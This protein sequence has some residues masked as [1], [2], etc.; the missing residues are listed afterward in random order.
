MKPC[1]TRSSSPPPNRSKHARQRLP[2][3][4]PASVVHGGATFATGVR[5]S[6]RLGATFFCWVAG[7]VPMIAASR[8]RVRRT[9]R[10]TCPHWISPAAERQGTCW[11]YCSCRQDV[12]NSA[13][14]VP[15]DYRSHSPHP[16]SRSLAT[17]PSMSPTTSP[18]C[19]QPTRRCS[20]VSDRCSPTRPT[21]RQNSHRTSSQ[22]RDARAHRQPVRRRTRQCHVVQRAEHRHARRA[23]HHVGRH[24]HRHRIGL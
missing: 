18:R 21:S 23:R 2:R 14:A 12:I 20:T 15:T 3:K 5:R 1:S 22:R 11:G 7:R 9:A 19:P 24:L 16:V 4:R 10:T 8:R 6:S 13:R 17:P